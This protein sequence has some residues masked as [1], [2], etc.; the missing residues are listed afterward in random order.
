MATVI[1]GNH[2]AVRVRQAER[3]EMRAFY[4]DVLGCKPKR[5]FDDKDDLGI[6]DDFHITFID[7]TESA[8]VAQRGATELA[9]IH[10]HFTPSR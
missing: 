8:A 7:A 1:S 9:P 4:R 5:K 3:G 6:G 2:S 10:G